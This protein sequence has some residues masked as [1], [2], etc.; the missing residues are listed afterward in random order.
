MSLHSMTLGRALPAESGKSRFGAV[1]AAFGD[2][3]VAMQQARAD[4]F[5]RPYLARLEETEL[6]RLG[7]SAAEI[8]SLRKDRHLPVIRWV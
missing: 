7:F 2:R 3:I 4:R 1:L 6:Q 5:V 8:E